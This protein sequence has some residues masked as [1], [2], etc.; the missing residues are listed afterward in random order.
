MASDKRRRRRLRRR[1]GSSVGRH[2][3]LRPAS[4]ARLPLRFDVG[5]RVASVATEKS[6][7]EKSHTIRVVESERHACAPTVRLNLD[8]ALPH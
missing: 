5:V 3:Q 1:V 8:L 7:A 4:R 2:L 6:A